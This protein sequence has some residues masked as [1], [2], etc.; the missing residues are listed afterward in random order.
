MLI[1]TASNKYHSGEWGRSRRPGGSPA[2]EEGEGGL[3]SGRG[4]GEG[5]NTSMPREN[6]ALPTVIPSDEL[7]LSIICFTILSKYGDMSPFMMEDTAAKSP[8]L[9]EKRAKLANEL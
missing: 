9:S 6:K 2:K 8:N 3:R 5:Q 7:I 4:L 1:N